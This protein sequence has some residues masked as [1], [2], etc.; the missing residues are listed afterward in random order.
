MKLEDFKVG[1]IYSLIDINS[2]LKYNYDSIDDVKNYG[3]RIAGCQFIVVH[4]WCCE[5]E[6]SFMLWNTN[7]ESGDVYKCVFNNFK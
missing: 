5:C 4:G 6:L 2:S 7:T 3:E 1:E